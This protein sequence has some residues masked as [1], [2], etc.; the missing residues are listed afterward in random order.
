MKY[1]VLIFIISIEVY[2][3][4]FDKDIEKLS[5]QYIDNLINQTKNRLQKDKYG[6]SDTYI[7]YDIQTHLQNVAIYA[8]ERNDTIILKKL[9]KLVTIPF[10]GK[11]LS[12]KG[13]WIDR[14]FYRGKES[15]IAISQY[16][17]LLTRVLSAS[18]RHNIDVSKYFTNKQY[19]KIINKHINKWMTYNIYYNLV[20][21]AQL[22]TV[23]SA[24]QFQDYMNNIKY[25]NKYRYNWEKYIKNYIN[26]SILKQMSYINCSGHKDKKC[27]V[28]SK[29]G[30]LNKK[31]NDYSY[32]AYDKKYKKI[33]SDNDPFAM[34]DSKGNIKQKSK[35]PIT[36]A[37]DL[38][39]ARRFNWFYESVNRIGKTVFDVKIPNKWIE[40]WA[41]NL[42]YNV[43]RE[44]KNKN[45]YFTIFSD[46]TDGWYRVGYAGRKGFGYAPGDM[47]IHF[48]ASSYGIIGVYN[49]RIYDCMDRWVRK[50]KSKM[51]VNYF[52]LD[53]LTSKQINMKRNIILKERN[54]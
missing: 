25:F 45:I 50:H 18:Q 30:W 44:D 11:Y 5:F 28:L 46:G 38:S 13:E 4:N 52:L 26:N 54:N 51:S 14:K 34:F 16:F 20:S 8:D 7:L 19:I 35:K 39:H 41:N 2:S 22:Y 47:D 10:N 9:L 6:F 23:M 42:A 40:S 49:N 17:A 21:D 33:N 37:T 1:I 31:F 48:V 43:C 36:G 32:S 53:Y 29:N 24:I 27:S 3:K 12:N 15:H